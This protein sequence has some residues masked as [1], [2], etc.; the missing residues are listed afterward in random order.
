[1]QPVKS[2]FS[3]G[4]ATSDD[5]LKSGPVSFEPAPA[6]P[7]F[8]EGSIPLAR[9]RGAQKSRMPPFLGLCYLALMAPSYIEVA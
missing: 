8:D 2:T 6:D 9:G 4:V 3:Y 1:M 7:R 5:L